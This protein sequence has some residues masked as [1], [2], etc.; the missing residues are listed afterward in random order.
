MRACEGD[1]SRS[2]W[3]AG[4]GVPPTGRTRSAPGPSS[5]VFETHD[6]AVTTRHVTVTFL[7]SLRADLHFC[8]ICRLSGAVLDAW[9]VD[10][11]FTALLLGEEHFRARAQ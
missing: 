1:V 3:A 9:E 10:H 5:R 2:A 7:W 8:G 4:P 6:A 11:A